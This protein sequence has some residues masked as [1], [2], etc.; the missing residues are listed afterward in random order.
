[1][2]VKKKIKNI[3]TD[4]LNV[5]IPLFKNKDAFL[6]FFTSKEKGKLFLTAEVWKN[7]N[8]L[9]FRHQVVLPL[10]ATREIFF[11]QGCSKN[12]FYIKSPTPLAQSREEKT[13][14]LKIEKETISMDLF[15]GDE[16]HNTIIKIDF[17]ELNA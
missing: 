1:M 15:I 14:Y 16:Y 5:L 11:R 10:N 12:T 8:T 4:S 6:M 13:I 2:L 9:F 7:N 3:S 17:F